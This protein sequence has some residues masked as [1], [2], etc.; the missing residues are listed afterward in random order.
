VYYYNSTRIR[1][2]A[3]SRFLIGT[4]AF[5]FIDDT[6]MAGRFGRRFMVHPLPEETFS[7]RARASV[8]PTIPDSGEVPFPGPSEMADVCLVPVLEKLVSTNKRYSGKNQR[9]IAD[10]YVAAIKMLKTYS[11]GQK[12]RPTRTRPKHGW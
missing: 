1:H 7:V 4:P 3:N 2:G 11:Q 9:E 8:A 5:Y 12:R 6:M 10:E